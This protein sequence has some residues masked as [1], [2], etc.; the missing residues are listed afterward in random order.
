MKELIG[1][2]RFKSSK[3][4]TKITVNEADI[5]DESKTATELNAFFIYMSSKL[6]SKRPNASTTF[7]F[8]IN[9][10]L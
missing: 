3:L 1:K 6:V 4:P 9:Q 8:Y 2:I 5:F 10:I 7:K